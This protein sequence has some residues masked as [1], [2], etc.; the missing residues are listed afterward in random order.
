MYLSQPEAH[1]T[2]DT[3]VT[4]SLSCSEHGSGTTTSTVH[5]SRPTTTDMLNSERSSTTT[6]TLGSTSTLQGHGHS[7]E[8]DLTSSSSD[9]EDSDD[10][11]ESTP[12]TNRRLGVGSH[13]NGVIVPDDTEASCNILTLV[14]DGPGLIMPPT[15]PEDDGKYFCAENI[16]SL[17][18]ML[19]LV[20]TK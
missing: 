3:I 19:C 4:S 9:D 6:L 8:D 1:R 11:E 20:T 10:D 18:L 12:H 17:A 16:E 2:T 14:D 13:G 5:T 15:M 7:D